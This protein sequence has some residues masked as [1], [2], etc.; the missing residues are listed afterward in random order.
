MDGLILRFAFLLWCVLEIGL[1]VHNRIARP[2]SLERDRGSRL[3]LLGAIVLGLW[4]AF[5]ARGL[6]ATRID[7]TA[8][9]LT[10]VGGALFL[11]GLALRIH[12]VATLGGFFTTSVTVRDH[13]R[14][15]RRGLYAQIRHPGYLGSLLIFTALGLSF[16]NWVSVA[17]L[18]ALVLPAFLNRIRIEERAL[19]EAFGEEY[20]AYMR[21]TKRLVPGLYQRSPRRIPSGASAS[22]PGGADGRHR[23]PTTDRSLRSRL[24]QLP[25]A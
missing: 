2:T 24:L 8:E 1:A 6:T 17:L 13:H 16:H 5:R 12:A 7:P 25:G 20:T 22:D 23:P 3:L 11:I 14:L 18:L 9:W 10:Y 15:V 19:A 21:T 4:L